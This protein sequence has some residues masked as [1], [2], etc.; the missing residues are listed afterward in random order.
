MDPGNRDKYDNFN[1]L[2]GREC[3]SESGLI[4]GFEAGSLGGAGR[5]M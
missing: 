5:L 2:N 1:P 4:H 3:S